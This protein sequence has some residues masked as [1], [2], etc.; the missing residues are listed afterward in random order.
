MPQDDLKKTST[1]EDSAPEI[2]RR[3]FLKVGTVVA[4]GAVATAAVPRPAQ[5][6]VRTPDGR[7]VSPPMP[8][9]TDPEDVNNLANAIIRAWNDDSYRNRLLTRD[10][11]TPRSALEE[12]G[13]KVDEP[14]VLTFSEYNAGYTM[15]K[16]SEIVYVLP[17]P[18]ASATAR[19]KAD[20]AKNLM[21]V[22]PF[23][24]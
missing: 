22:I 5:A 15:R 8:T 4:V 23:G 18:P 17:D 2:S 14:V 13:V 24:M 7:P 6:V 21:R 10:Y 3:R 20:Q 1:P 11:V 9:Y 16:L 19:Q 12:V